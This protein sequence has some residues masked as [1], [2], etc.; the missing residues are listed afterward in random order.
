MSKLFQCK[1]MCS[2]PTV[3]AC[4]LGA[5]KNHLIETALLNTHNKMVWLKNKKK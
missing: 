3:K 4:V 5:Q 2:L 1:K